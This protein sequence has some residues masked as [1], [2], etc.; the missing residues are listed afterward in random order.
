MERRDGF[1]FH[2]KWTETK[3]KSTLSP[4]FSLLRHFDKAQRMERY[5]RPLDVARDDKKGL[6]MTWEKDREDFIWIL[7][8]GFRYYSYFCHRKTWV[9]L[10]TSFVFRRYRNLKPSNALIA[11]MLCLCVR[12]RSFVCNTNF[13]NSCWVLCLQKTVWWVVY[14]DRCWAPGGAF[15]WAALGNP[16]SLSVTSGLDQR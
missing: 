6:R 3:P 4:L 2:K 10:C 5:Q 15:R 11:N 14:P 16:R 12:K 1:L 13:K 8:G 7:F 9:R